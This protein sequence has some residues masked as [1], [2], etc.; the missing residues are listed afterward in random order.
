[1]FKTTFSNGKRRK[2]FKTFLIPIQ[3]LICLAF[4]HEMGSDYMKDGNKTKSCTNELPFTLM[5]QSG[6]L[7]MPKKLVRSLFSRVA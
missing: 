7:P 2:N 4:L 5:A 3:H 1:M 6:F